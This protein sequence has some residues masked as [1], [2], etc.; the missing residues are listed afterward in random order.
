MLQTDCI[1]KYRNDYPER[2]NERYKE[3]QTEEEHSFKVPTKK[4]FCTQWNCI[5]YD[6]D[7]ITLVSGKQSNSE[8]VLHVN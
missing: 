3:R 1:L 6:H 5:L 8:A 2:S 4:L 7:I